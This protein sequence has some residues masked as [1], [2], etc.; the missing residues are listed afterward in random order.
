MKLDENDPIVRCVR[1]AACLLRST[2][3]RRVLCNGNLEKQLKFF[4]ALAWEH[5]S[6][7]H[8]S[9]MDKSLKFGPSLPKDPSD[10]PRKRNNAAVDLLLLDGTNPEFLIETKSTFSDRLCDGDAKNSIMQLEDYWHTLQAQATDGATERVIKRL[11]QAR[12]KDASDFCKALGKSSLYIVHFVNRNL[13]EEN[14]HEDA[15]FPYLIGRKFWKS[16]WEKW[17][18][19]TGYPIPESPD[20]SLRE[21]ARTYERIGTTGEYSGRGCRISTAACEV[22]MV[23]EP[24]FFLKALVVRVRCEL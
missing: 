2:R 13:H 15:T 10:K 17:R 18:N 12:K 19:S 3:P 11:D 1:N 4:L 20:G 6:D 21:F 24:D 14:N 9:V 23:P 22:N 16:T 7:S 5:E 8:I